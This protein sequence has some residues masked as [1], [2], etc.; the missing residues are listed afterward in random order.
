[1]YLG[2]LVELAPA[3]EIYAAPKHPYT[4]ALLAAIPIPDPE[5][6]KT[7]PERL[8]GDVP[9]PIAPFS[10]CRFHPRCPQATAR[11]REQEPEFKEVSPGHFAACFLYE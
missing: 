1:M 8:K 7:A 2:K 9:N 10:G 6:R 3:G 11:C 4:I 5:A